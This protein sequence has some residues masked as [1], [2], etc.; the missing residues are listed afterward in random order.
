M[1]V[2]RDEMSRAVRLLVDGE[3][4]GRTDY[5]ETSWAGMELLEGVG[6]AI[7]KKMG[8]DLVIEDWDRYGDDDDGHAKEGEG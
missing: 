4:V 3:E 7:A 6:S 2:A 5:D 1:T 8:W